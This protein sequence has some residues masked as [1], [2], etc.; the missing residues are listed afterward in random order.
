MRNYS[1]LIFLFILTLVMAGCEKDKDAE[2]TKEELLMA[3]NWKITAVKING[4]VNGTAGEVDYYNYLIAC[5]T[6]NFL[7]FN[8]GGVVVVDE[9]AAKCA[10]TAPQ[11]T[12]GTWSLKE[13]AT[14]DILTIGG[15]ILLSYGLVKTSDRDL[16][17]V[18]L[19]NQTLRVTFNESV[20]LPGFPIAIPATIDLTLTAQ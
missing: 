3:K 11:T 6:D 8:T 7:K 4:T 9:G 16:T 17:V 12:Q 20:T 18:T 14:G 15:N 19:N 1:S 13:N 10:P 5:Q 2:P